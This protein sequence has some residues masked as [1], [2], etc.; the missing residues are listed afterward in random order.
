MQS[1]TDTQLHELA[2]KRVEFR[3]HLIV[4]CVINS[5]LW[6]LWFITGKG[7]PWPVWPLAGWGVG[8]FFHYMFDYRPSRLLSEEEEYK[9]LKREMEQHKQVTQ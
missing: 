9:K 6:A 3:T 5:V 4:Y 7:Y 2:R 1:P 8:L